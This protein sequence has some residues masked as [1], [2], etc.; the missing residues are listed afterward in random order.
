MVAGMD[1]VTA[2]T[3][4]TET[5]RSRLGVVTDSQLDMAS[6]CEEW[7]VRDLV[8]HVIGGNNMAIALVGGCSTEEALS[9]IAAGEASEDV[10][11][12]CVTSL[13]AQLSALGPDLDTT[14]TVHHPMG[15]IPAAQLFDFRIGDLLLH[16]WD[17]ARATGG[18]EL[19][20]EDLVV[21]VYASLEPMEAIIASIGVFGAGPSGTL[22]PDA[23]MQTRLLDFT[24]R[25][26]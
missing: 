15:D 11:G 9:F 8:V 22:G 6:P 7:S 19:L 20:P 17:L 25:R 18:D 12:T 5:F 24:G 10:F 14:K 3:T 2:L 1:P 26:P 4:A 16:T 21:R 23:D 13:E